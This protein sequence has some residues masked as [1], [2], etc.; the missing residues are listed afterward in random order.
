LKRTVN[1]YF[2]FTLN[3]ERERERERERDVMVG[4]NVTRWK[5][6]MSLPH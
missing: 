1:K 3:R 6:N 5:N 2:L 4:T